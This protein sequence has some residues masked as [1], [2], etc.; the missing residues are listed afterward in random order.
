MSDADK[1]DGPTPAAEQPAQQPAAPPPVAE[2]AQKT[3]EPEKMQALI[4]K[5]NS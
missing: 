5:L 4:E 3:D 2:P 1:P